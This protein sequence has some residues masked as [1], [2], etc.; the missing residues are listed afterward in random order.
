MSPQINVLVPLIVVAY[1]AIEVAAKVEFTNF[2]CTSFDKEFGDFEYCY[3]KS[4]NRTYKYMST[5]FNLYQAPIKKIKVNISLHKRFS[6]Y[7]P[8]M[9]NVTVDGCRFLN[10]PK[11]NPVILFFYNIITSFSNINHS[12]PFN[13]A[14]IME[15]IPT[16]TFNHHFSSVLPFPEG[17]YMLQIVW[18]AYDINRAV[19]KLYFTLS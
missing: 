17:D 2:V 18:I 6:G 5:K 8:F 1:V 11:S 14:V 9:Y 15:K 7:R 16:T 13:D 12:C 4:V 10:N 3:L 19:T